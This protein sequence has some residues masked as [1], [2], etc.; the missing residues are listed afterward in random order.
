[1]GAG[2]RRAS[3]RLDRPGEAE[4][5]AAQEVEAAGLDRAM[6]RWADISDRRRRSCAIF[7][8]AIAM[9]EE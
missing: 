3:L 8:S 7:E 4:A 9:H 6:Q 5:G 2:R 1:M